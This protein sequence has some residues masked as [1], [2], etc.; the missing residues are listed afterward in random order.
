[1]FYVSIAKNSKNMGHSII[2]TELSISV[3]RKECLPPVI[4]CQLYMDFKFKFER[5]KSFKK[6]CMIYG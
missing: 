2:G 6:S 1:M 3:H 4:K 5:Q